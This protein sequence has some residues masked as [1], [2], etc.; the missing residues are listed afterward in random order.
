MSEF[1]LRK[2]KMRKFEHEVKEKDII[3][4]ILDTAPFVVVSATDEDG[5]P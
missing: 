4:A 1:G 2:V 3:A 5:L